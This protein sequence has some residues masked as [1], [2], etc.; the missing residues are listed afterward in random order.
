MLRLPTRSATPKGVVAVS[1]MVLLA[2]PIASAAVPHA[3]VH[4]GIRNFGIPGFAGGPAAPRP[5]FDARY[6]PRV[7][8]AP[9]PFHWHGAWTPQPGYYDHHWTFGEILPAGWFAPQFWIVDY[10]DFD[11]PP[12]PL[13]Y[14]WVRVGPDAL[15]VNLTNGTVVEAVY[16]LFI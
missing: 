6:F 2:A 11:L 15:L 10:Y 7:V 4:Q 14:A 9:V 16:G 13:G 12:P 1:L 5:H 8:H 3:G